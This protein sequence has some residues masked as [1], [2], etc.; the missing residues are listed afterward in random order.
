MHVSLIIAV[1]SSS[2]KAISSNFFYSE[3]VTIFPSGDPIIALSRSNDVLL[4]CGLEPDTLTPGINYTTRWI[5]PGGEI[6]NSTRTTIDS[7]RYVFSESF[8]LINGK[9]VPGTSLIVFP[10]SYQD[11]GMYTCEGRS[12]APGASAQWATT[13]FE[14]Q[15]NCELDT[16][17][18][19]LFSEY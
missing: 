13:S 17:K 1:S 12:T 4:V 16:S 2:R 5:L 19:T 8:F 10:L 7:K 6:V 9:F 15:L 11:A 18:Y 3:R 14:L